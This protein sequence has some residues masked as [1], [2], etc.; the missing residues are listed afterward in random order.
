MTLPR[1][2]EL[3]FAALDDLAFAAQRGRLAEGG[4][5]FQLEARKLGPVLEWVRLSQEWTLPR[6]E[7]LPWLGLNRLQPLLEA[8]LTP[9]L[10]WITPGDGHIGFYK[11]REGRDE[12]GWNGFKITAHKAALASGFASK[13]AFQLIASLGELFDNVFE[14][15]GSPQTGMVSF[16]AAAHGFEFV[17]SDAGVGVLA[18]LRTNAE[19]SGLRDSGDALRAALTDGVSRFGK[20]SR[21]GH[22]FRQLFKSLAASQGVLRFRSDD[23]ALLLEGSSPAVTQAKTATKPQLPGLFISVLSERPAALQCASD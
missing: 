23:H 7:R 4:P 18:S 21:R 15:S 9:R 12:H 13:T 2:H 5:G 16:C 6:P 19:F 11:A 17:V 22:G 8:L 1:A 10:T 3:T 14:H 20:E